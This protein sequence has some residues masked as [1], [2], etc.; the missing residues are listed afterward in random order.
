MGGG[1][2]HLQRP[3]LARSSSALQPGDLFQSLGVQ[4]VQWDLDSDTLDSSN[5][6]QGLQSIGTRMRFLAFLFF[7]ILLF[8]NVIEKKNGQIFDEFLEK[9]PLIHLVFRNIELSC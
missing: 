6:A 4:N 9:L 3:C 8:E 7:S 2:P 5:L 1:D